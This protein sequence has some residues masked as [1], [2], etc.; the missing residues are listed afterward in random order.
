MSRKIQSGGHCVR[1]ANQVCGSFDQALCNRFDDAIR[2]AHAWIGGLGEH[3]ALVVD[4]IDPNEIGVRG[5]R[6]FARKKTHAGEVRDPFH[7]LPY[8]LQIELLNFF[9]QHFGVTIGEAIPPAP[10]ERAENIKHP[11][12][13]GTPFKIAWDDFS[14]QQVMIVG[15]RNHRTR[16]IFLIARIENNSFA[17]VAARG[18]DDEGIAQKLALFG[19][20]LNRARGGGIENQTGRNRHAGRFE[21]RM[22]HAFVEGVLGERRRIDHDGFPMVGQG[23]EAMKGIF[24]QM[25]F[26]VH[27]QQRARPN[28]VALEGFEERFDPDRF[29][30]EKIQSLRRAHSL[31]AMDEKAIRIQ[32]V[33]HHQVVNA[34]HN[35]KYVSNRRQPTAPARSRNLPAHR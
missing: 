23:D 18:F 6:D 26:A 16:N 35:L 22:Q 14:L 5:L 7:P 10:P 19:R 25:M 4:V 34:S 12:I 13:R 27:V 17:S 24:G 21:P 31:D 3:V 11:P 33:R 28:I 30:Q 1:A 8:G 20:E 2:D 15:P 29:D 9:G 32:L